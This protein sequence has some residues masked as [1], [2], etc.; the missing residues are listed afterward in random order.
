MNEALVGSPVQ[1]ETSM[2][3]R[4]VLKSSKRLDNCGKGHEFAVFS[5]RGARVC[6]R[7]ERVG[8]ERC[9]CVRVRIPLTVSERWEDRG[10]VEGWG[11]VRRERHSCI[12]D[13]RPGRACW[14][15]RRSQ[16]RSACF[17]F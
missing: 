4:L 12:P 16:A 5:V 14:S 3:S 2:I 15:C 13:F 6:R 7:S 1:E 17:V 10:R 8:M 9:V 11:D